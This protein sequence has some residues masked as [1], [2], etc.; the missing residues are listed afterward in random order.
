MNQPQFCSHENPA[1][2]QELK[3]G[4]QTAA[5]IEKEQCSGRRVFGNV[6]NDYWA[7]APRGTRRL[8]IAATTVTR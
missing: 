5:P 1:V 8:T 3:R 7:W 2:Q 4:A 6:P